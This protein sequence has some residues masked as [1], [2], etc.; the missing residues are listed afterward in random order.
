MSWLEYFTI[1]S[2]ISFISSS[3]LIAHIFLSFYFRSHSLKPFQLF[4]ILISLVDL[5][6]DIGYAIPL[7]CNLTVGLL[8]FGCLTKT[9]VFPSFIMYMY[10][11][12]LGNSAERDIIFWRFVYLGLV[13]LIVPLASL[14]FLWLFGDFFDDICTE[15]D[16]PKHL[17]SPIAQN[18][19]C[20]MFFLSFDC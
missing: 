3:F 14:F 7:H 8:M 19:P 1:P 18:P 13:S 5:I 12:M 17:E 2:R 20:T 10:Y 11:L 9:T 15:N 4:S 6:Q 16:F